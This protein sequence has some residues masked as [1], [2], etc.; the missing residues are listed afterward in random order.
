[1]NMQQVK[2]AAHRWSEG[3][4]IGRLVVEEMVTVEEAERRLKGVEEGGF[5]APMSCEAR[6][7]VAVIV[8][9]RD[10]AEQLGAF[11]NHMHPFLQRQQL[12]YSIYIVEQAGTDLFNR[13]RLLNVGFLKARQE[14]PWD[15]YAF[16]DIDMLPLND[17]HL[18]HCSPQ[19]RHLA[20][21]P[22][23]HNYKSAHHMPY[24]KYFGGACL[25]TE[26]HLRRVNGWSNAYWGWG[27]EDD[28]MWRRIRLT[29]MSVWR[30]PAHFASYKMITHKPQTI[31]PERYK[32]L[33]RN[34]GR[35]VQDGLSNLNYTIM[36][37]QR[38]P[39]YTHI[40]ADIGTS[41]APAGKNK[42]KG[43]R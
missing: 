3:H 31:N 10:R 26:G 32:V 42:S 35:Y 11:L 43:G 23:S 8:P 5:W 39:L 27:G 33:E 38:R 14:G 15:C 29:D 9:Y 4:P 1:M 7:R 22:S 30:Y 12:N 18:Y 19:P 25:M 20:V 16:H 40:L 28:D 36:K 13:A 2:L 21:S 17:Y 6:W 37:T 34:T 24:D 41:V